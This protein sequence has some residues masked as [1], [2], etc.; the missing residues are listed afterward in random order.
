MFLGYINNK[1]IKI[2]ES[3][4]HRLCKLLLFADFIC[5]EDI[6]IHFTELLFCMR[7]GTKTINLKFI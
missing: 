2:S 3:I 6:N 1:Q 5:E 7:H 4:K